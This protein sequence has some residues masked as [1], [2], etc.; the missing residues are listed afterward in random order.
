MLVRRR[1][2][3]WIAPRKQFKIPKILEGKRWFLDGIRETMARKD[4]IYKNALSENM[5]KWLDITYAHI[6]CN[7]K[8]KGMK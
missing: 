7:I 5:N 3:Y 2:N 6:G 8:L 1:W 4:E